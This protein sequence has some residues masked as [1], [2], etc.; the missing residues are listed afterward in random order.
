MFCYKQ[1]GITCFM[2]L[3][4][5]IGTMTK[6][7]NAKALIPMKQQQEQQWICVCACL[8]IE[9]TNL[10]SVRFPHEWTLDTNQQDQFHFL[11]NM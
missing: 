2:I 3:R 11:V 9:A 8:C 1:P 6:H 10:P 7:L 5:L 4:T